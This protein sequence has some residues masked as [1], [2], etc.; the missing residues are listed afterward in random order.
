MRDE[1]SQPAN[2]PWDVYLYARRK[3]I[4]YMRDKLKYDNDQIVLNI[5]ILPDEVDLILREADNAQTK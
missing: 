2:N 4:A 5:N 3:A 1:F